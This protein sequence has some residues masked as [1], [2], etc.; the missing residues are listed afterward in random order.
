MRKKPA[1]PGVMRRCENPNCD[2]LTDNGRFCSIDC[3]RFVAEK[4]RRCTCGVLFVIPPSHPNQKHH[5][6]VCANKSRIKDVSEAATRRR[7]SEHRSRKRIAE[8]QGPSELVIKP[9]VPKE[10]VQIMTEEEQAAINKAANKALTARMAQPLTVAMAR[11]MGV[12]V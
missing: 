3:G 6:K 5:N 9:W 12:A 1:P 4:C 8:L 11:R 10:K 7:E 2:E